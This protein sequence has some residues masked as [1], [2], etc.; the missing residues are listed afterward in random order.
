MIFV[1]FHQRKL[2]G[3]FQERW[4]V[5]LNHFLF[6]CQF[7][8]QNSL[9]LTNYPTPPILTPPELMSHTTNEAMFQCRQPVTSISRILIS[10]K[11]DLLGCFH[12]NINTPFS[13]SPW[14]ECLNTSDLFRIRLPSRSRAE[15]MQRNLKPKSE[16]WDH[17]MVRHAITQSNKHWK[18]RSLG[19]KWLRSG[20]KQ[21]LLKG[22]LQTDSS[23]YNSKLF[24][25]RQFIHSGK[26][27]CTE[28][29]WYCTLSSF[30][31]KKLQ[32]NS[33]FLKEYFSMW[34]C[35]LQ[36]DAVK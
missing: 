31:I 19:E 36:K 13:W 33:I 6:D 22:G 28:V 32:P 25:S 7:K 17:L 18:H 20:R 30:F 8:V 35:R 29:Q 11:N 9:V 24:G 16:L 1:K 15:E 34:G 10:L 27:T 14:W 4:R 3:D 21:Y 26:S 5:S 12:W 2:S 23:Q